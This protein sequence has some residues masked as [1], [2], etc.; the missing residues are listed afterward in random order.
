M[1]D[2]SGDDDYP[3]VGNP[4][5]GNN[6]CE[7][8]DD[9]DDD[10]A[11]GN[12]DEPPAGQQANEQLVRVRTRSGIINLKKSLQDGAFGPNPQN[13]AIKDVMIYYR[14]NDCSQKALRSIRVRLIYYERKRDVPQPL[15]KEINTKATNFESY[16]MISYDAINSPRPPLI[17]LTRTE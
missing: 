9:E 7:F 15:V 11:N 12:L 3:G 16:M 6:R 8:D 10:N 17:I 5:G 14:L 13:G 2:A 4:G 1:C